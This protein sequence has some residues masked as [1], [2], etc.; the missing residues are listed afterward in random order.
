MTSSEPKRHIRYPLPSAGTANRP[1]YPLGLFNSRVGWRVDSADQLEDAVLSSFEV[2]YTKASS[3]P[4]I[5]AIIYLNLIALIV[6]YG[7]RPFTLPG[8]C[9]CFFCTIS[10]RPR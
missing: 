6:D 7:M 4:G 9:G 2:L 3:D 5:V 1:M 8:R 10:R